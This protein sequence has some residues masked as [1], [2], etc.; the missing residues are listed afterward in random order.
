MCSI[1][2]LV[3]TRVLGLV[4]LA[5]WGHGRDW[6]VSDGPWGTVEAAALLGRTGGSRTRR[7]WGS[8]WRHKI[9]GLLA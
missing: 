8:M 5:Y 4:R 7:G 2:F 3:R 6:Q 9:T 1:I